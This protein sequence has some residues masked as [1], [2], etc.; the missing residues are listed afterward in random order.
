M[1]R[2]L[3]RV[4]RREVDRRIREM[5]MDGHRL[6]M[7]AE[8]ELAKGNVNGAMSFA[9]DALRGD[10]RHVGAL[11]VLAKAQWQTSLCDDLI[12]TLY[13]LIELNPYE[14]GYHSLLAGAF[15]SLGRCGD[16][17]KA[18]IRAVDLG[19]P[20]SEEMDATLED[21]KIWQGSLVTE[22]LLVDEVFKAAFNQDPAKAC[23]D[24]GFDF[25]VEPETT[26]MAI[27]ERELRSSI[28]ARPS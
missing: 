3:D 22:L 11:E 28:F 20:R 5:P 16:A 7:C 26:E 10:P 27:V 13:R 17:V 12:H 14:P 2:K 1:G 21:L 9:K 4:D 8:R 6:T 15:Q 24:R 19:L 18:Y 23:A 25:A